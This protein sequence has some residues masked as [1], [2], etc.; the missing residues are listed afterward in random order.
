MCKLGLKAAGLPTVWGWKTAHFMATDFTKLRLFSHKVPFIMNTISTPLRLTLYAGTV[1]LFAEASEFQFSVVCKVASWERILQGTKRWKLKGA[2]SGLQ[3]GW[4]RASSRCGLLLVHL[5]LASSG[6]VEDSCWWDSWREQPQLR[7]IWADL[8]NEC[9]VS[10]KQE[11][12]SSPHLPCGNY[13]V[14]LITCIVLWGENILG[15]CISLGV[16]VLRASK[17]YACEVYLLCCCIISRLLAKIN[18]N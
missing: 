11:D 12:E 18:P 3:E 1:K 16:S 15:L 8:N 9:K 17:G 2:K 7:A 5:W 4:G 6:R 13:R 14:C 10:A